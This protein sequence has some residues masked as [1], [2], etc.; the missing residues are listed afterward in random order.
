MAGRQE[1]EPRRVQ[2]LAEQR[3]LA[4]PAALLLAD[5]RELVEPF[6]LAELAFKPAQ[7]I[8]EP[9]EPYALRELALSVHWLP[10]VFLLR[11]PFVLPEPSVRHTA[12]DRSQLL[13]DQVPT[14]DY[15]QEIEPAPALPGDRLG[16]FG[17]FKRKFQ[18]TH[19]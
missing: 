9:A 18:L 13:P 8:F 10:Q 3:E 15:W 19:C 7:L 5:C 12:F 1:V 16:F 14:V 11:N 2:P 4:P 17:F 6:V